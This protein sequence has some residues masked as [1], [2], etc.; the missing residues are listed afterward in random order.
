MVPRMTV[1]TQLNKII[2]AGDGVTT[3]FTFNFPGVSASGIQVFVTDNLGNINQLNSNLYTLVLNA[4]VGAN[5]TGVGGFVIYPLS[6]SPLALGSSLTILRSLSEI[7]PVSLANQGTLYQTVIEKVFDYITMITQQITEL[8]GRNLT[9]PV[10]DP[11]PNPL[12]TAVARAN[13]LLGFDG[14]GNPIATT[15][16]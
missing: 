5:P 2:Y 4:P 3:S 8:M 7:Q 9:V 1:S 12:P 10:S 13:L 14:A 15:G 6:G 16:V 11:V